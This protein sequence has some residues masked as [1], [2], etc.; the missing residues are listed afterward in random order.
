MAYIASEDYTNKRIYLHPDTFSMVEID[1]I[2]VYQEHIIR[3]KLNVNGERN[4][5]KMVLAFGNEDIGGE[6]TP[7]YVDLQQN[8]RL[9]PHDA[10]HTPLITPTPL[11]SR[12]E[13]LSG[14]AL[15][16]RSSLTGGVEVD[17]DY[18]PEKT[19]F[20]V[21]NTGSGIQPSDVTDIAN[22]S[23]IA[24]DSILTDDFD[25]TNATVDLTPITDAIAALKDFDPLNDVIARVTLVDTVTTNTDM[26]GTDGANT[27]IPDN[28]SITSILADTAD[29][30][31]NQSSWLTATGYAP[32]ATVNAIKTKVDSLTNTDLSLVAKSVEISSLKDFDPANDTVS[33]VTTVTNQTTIDVNAIALAVEAI[34]ID[35]FSAVNSSISSADVSEIVAAIKAKTDKLVFTKSGEIDANVKSQ[36]G[37]T[38]YGSGTNSDRWRGTS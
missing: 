36:N 35:E 26:R 32:I 1:L 13:S 23:A 33:T 21:V 18:R 10:S 14:S 22:A 15:F 29:L 25:S 8:V 4:F 5:T 7:R 34:L 38:I 24:V 12:A 3:R 16:D 2:N 27:V 17:I 20:R 31:V 30:Q 37:A 11:I 6:F 19:G 28:T 9:V